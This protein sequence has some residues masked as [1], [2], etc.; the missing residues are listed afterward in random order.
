LITVPEAKCL[1]SVL[2]PPK[3]SILEVAIILIFWRL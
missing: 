3:Y 1:H 2:S